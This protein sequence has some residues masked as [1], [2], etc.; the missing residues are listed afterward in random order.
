M[1]L[2]STNTTTDCQQQQN[3]LNL[4]VKKHYPSTS[5]TTHSTVNSTVTSSSV[6]ANIVQPLIPNKITRL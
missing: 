3:D 4:Y 1:S 2:T 5:S 6:T